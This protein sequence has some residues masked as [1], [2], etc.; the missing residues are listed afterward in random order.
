MKT[1]RIE[2]PDLLFVVDYSHDEEAPSALTVTGW[3]TDEVD[4]D[5][6]QYLTEGVEPHVDGSIKRDGCANLAF[7]S[8]MHFCGVEHVRRH[9]QRLE[10][11]YQEHQK[12]FPDY[13]G[14]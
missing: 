7:D 2:Y 10:A 3:G 5:G 14:H 4:W 12:V 13:D 6:T 9:A 1:Y 8:C 11:L